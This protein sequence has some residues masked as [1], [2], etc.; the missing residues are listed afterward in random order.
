MPPTFSDTKLFSLNKA[1]RGG[2]W[3]RSSYELYGYTHVGKSSLAYYLAGRVRPDGD[4]H[5]A[6]YEG[7]DPIYLES[8]LKMAEFNGKVIEADTTTGESGLTALKDALLDP[9]TQAIVLD[10]VGALIPRAEIE[11]EISDANMG[12]KARLMSRAMRLLMYGLKRNPAC[13]FLVNHLHPIMSLG[14]GATTTGGVAIHNLSAVRIKLYPEKIE[15][16]Y[17][18]VQGRIEKL[19]WGGKGGAFKFVLLPGIGIHPGLSAVIDCGW[20]EIATIDRIVK[21]NDKSYGYFS[22]MVEKVRDGDVEITQ[23]FVEAI[24]VSGADSKDDLGTDD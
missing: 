15:D 10:S 14:K 17:F 7:Y 11:G 2:L 8:S 24:N 21:L 9:N 12:L 3:H 6:D 22:K 18:I 20:Y 4:I 19:R 23:P 1:L 5:L 16:D 13:A